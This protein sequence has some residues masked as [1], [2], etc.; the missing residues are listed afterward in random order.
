MFRL[1]FGL[2]AFAFISAYGMGSLQQGSPPQGHKTVSAPAAPTA[3]PERDL[4]VGLTRHVA[5]PTEE[6]VPEDLATLAMGYL[7]TQVGWILAQPAEPTQRGAG[8][9]LVNRPHRID[10]D[11]DLFEKHTAEIEQESI[12]LFEADGFSPEMARFMAS[13]NA[14]FQT[15]MDNSNLVRHQD[16]LSGCEIRGGI[17]RCPVQHPSQP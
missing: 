1:L 15:V 3:A 11:T 12:Q 9:I 6:Q 2:C 10:W 8:E 17:K 5:P 7:M 16:Y 13:F 4:S 14:Q